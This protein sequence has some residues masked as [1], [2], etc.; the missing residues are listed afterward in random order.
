MDT[1]KKVSLCYNSIITQRNF[2]NSI[3][4]DER[5]VYSDKANQSIVQQINIDHNR[6]RRL[7]ANKYITTLLLH[8]GNVVPKSTTCCW[9]LTKNNEDLIM[10]QFFV[11]PQYRFGLDISSNVLRDNNDVGATFMSSL[12]YHCTSIPI[13][14]ETNGNKIYIEGPKDMYNFAWGSNGTNREK[15]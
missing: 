3:H 9:R 8:T 1:I 4:M 7:A 15:N 13:W 11:S 12:F 6:K 2:F 10:H 5:S 14:K